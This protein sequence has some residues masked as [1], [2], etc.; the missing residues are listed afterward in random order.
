MKQFIWACLLC[1]VLPTAAIAQEQPHEH[2]APEKL[3]KVSFP[4]SC[5]PEAQATFDRAVALLHSFAYS[6]ADETFAAASAADPQ[7]AMAHWGRAM[8]HF[9]Q[10]WEPP[11][12]SSGLVSGRAEIEK[13][14]QIG[15]KLARERGYIAALAVIYE[16]AD[17]VPYAARARQYQEA[18]G[19]LAAQNTNDAETQIFYALA[20][21]AT[22]PPDDR[23]HSNQKRAAQILEPLHRELPEHP[24]IVH[25]LIHA[26][27]NSE[28]AERGLPYARAYAQIAPSAP[29]ALHM[30][31]HIFTRLGMWNESIESNLAAQAAA[32]QQGDI[33]EEL[34]AMD[35]LVYA[36]LQKGRNE[37]AAGVLAQLRSMTSLPEGAFKVGY[38]AT[39]MPVRYAVERRQWA[40]AAHCSAAQGTLPWVEALAVWARAL[41]LARG[42]NP[43]AA[44]TETALLQDLQEKS[45][46][47]ENLYWAQQVAIQVLEASAWVSQASG[48]SAEAV[49]A[50]RKAADEEDGIEKRPVTPGPIIPAREQLADLLLE[51]GHAQ[52]ALAEFETALLSS[53]GRRRA[54]EG[55]LQ[56]AEQAN[57][58][59]KTRLYRV[60]LQKDR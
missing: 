38:A 3:G 23:T 59:I 57:D 18:I 7:C 4:T 35:Y 33:G 49:T 27:D 48:K 51:Q 13:A 43:A 52:E 21:L 36:Y 26:C 20:L 5:R 25:Y 24:G 22:A 55:A 31:S 37:D 44:Q 11:V 53:P 54:L 32:H 12:S 40:E 19:A 9:H 39:A 1:L 14:Q 60:A 42:G 10:L 30:P 45:R 8:T 50:L 46:A 15:S 2:P 47:L 34:H 56:A 28:M 17:S 16:R 6:V 41:G 29:H 58:E